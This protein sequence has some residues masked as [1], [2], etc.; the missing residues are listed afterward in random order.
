[1][2]CQIFA[3]IEAFEADRSLIVMVVGNIY[4]VAVNIEN[5]FS[6]DGY[7]VFGFVFLSYAL[8]E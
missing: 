2:E 7:S 3:D 4:I 6:S 5:V 1:V 8:W